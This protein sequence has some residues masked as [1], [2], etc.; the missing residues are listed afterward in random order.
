MSFPGEI[1]DRFIDYLHDDRASLSQ[2]GLVCREWT[3]SSRYHL[4]GY[5]AIKLSDNETTLAVLCSPKSS[6]PRYVRHVTVSIGDAP[7]RMWFQLLLRPFHAVTSLRLEDCGYTV[8][9]TADAWIHSLLSQVQNL[10]IYR[11]YFRSTDDLIQLVS[12]GP[13]I[14]KL[15]LDHLDV[16]DGAS[17]SPRQSCELPS[18]VLSIC[19][20]SIAISRARL[21]RFL[22]WLSSAVTNHNIHHLR[23]NDKDISASPAISGL[24][25]T[26]G[27]SLQTLSLSYEFNIRKSESQHPLHQ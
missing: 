27:K 5:L 2:C 23:L 19:L 24:L 18:N 9:P 17:T 22:L 7:D 25:G 20:G 6:I 3:P 8:R 4:F 15:V 14:T 12:S 1:V 10:A 16:D 11:T 26:I 21:A 13:R